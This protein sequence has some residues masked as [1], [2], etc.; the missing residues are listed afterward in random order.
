MAQIIARGY[1]ARIATY[2]L[3]GELALGKILAG[4]LPRPAFPPRLRETAPTAWFRLAAGGLSFAD[5]YAGRQDRVAC[6][7]NLWQAVLAAAQGRRAAAG[8]PPAGRVGAQRAAA[9][10]TGRR[11]PLSF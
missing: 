11:S 3:A 1:V 7:A 2:I 8:E 5:V 4:E 6:L 10:R 9:Y